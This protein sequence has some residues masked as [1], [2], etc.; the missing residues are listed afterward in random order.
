MANQEIFFGEPSP[1][2][3]ELRRQKK[4]LAVFTAF[5]APYIFLYG[6]YR[7]THGATLSGVIEIVLGSLLVMNYLAFLLHRRIA[8]AKPAVTIASIIVN[9]MVLGT[10]G[11]NG[12][13]AY[14]SIPF[15]ALTFLFQG[16]RLGALYNAVFF[17]TM[18]GYAILVKIGVVGS[19]YT[20]DQLKQLWSVLIL[21]NALGYAAENGWHKAR[22][23][24]ERQRG[25]LNTLLSN[26]PVGA[27]MVK[28]D[29]TLSASNES[30][31][32]LFGQPILPTVKVNDVPKTYGFK[33]EDGTPYPVEELPL[34]M[35]L[36]TGK[37]APQTKLFI[38]RPDGST[39]VL[40]VTASPVLDTDGKAIAAVAVYEDM[41]KEHEI[42]QIKSEFV[43]LTSHQLKTPLTAVKWA[44][45]TLLDGGAGALT[46][47]QKEIVTETG[48][49][50]ERLRRL[51][52]DLLNVSR[53]ETGRK[54]NLEKK[55]TDIA[56]MIRSVAAES[57]ATAG[58]RRV[59]LDVSKIPDGLLRDVD[60]HKIREVF[61]NLVG[62]AIKY[63]AEGGRVEIGVARAGKKAG[64]IYVKDG[65][66][67][68]PAEQQDKIFQKFFRASNVE[69]KKEG[70]GLGLYL[71]KAI[72]EKHGGSIWFESQEGKGTTFYVAL[73]PAA[74]AS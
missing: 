15:P 37:A 44:M 56:T 27:V 4:M 43:S 51:V 32:R 39:V 6:V 20:Y 36:K 40:R 50:V 38:S 59:T 17:V 25:Q 70:T 13:A 61:T 58:Q 30:A 73:P 28:K 42:D 54:F 29:G 45:E 12:T 35:S 16:P 55:P 49:T 57:S 23:T 19:Y 74:P 26:L 65:G 67:G 41:T 5:L 21:T 31:A 33:K 66:I 62:N 53:I 11:I 1:Q 69:A 8:I 63:S 18:V 52:A 22:Q 14:W 7:V 9:V 46:P 72:V 64:A 24:L 3:N 2:A 34:I 60:E 10:G 71:A 68:I 48:A 47:E